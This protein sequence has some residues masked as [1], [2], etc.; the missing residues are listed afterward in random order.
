VGPVPGPPEF[1]TALRDLGYIEGQNLVVDA[2]YAGGQF[3]RLPQLARELVKLGPDIILAPG[4]AEAQAAKRVTT[5]IPIVMVT[6]VDPVG[7]GLVTSLARPGGNVTGLTSTAGSELHGKRLQMLRELAPG[8]TRI[9]LLVNPGTPATP[10]RVQATE[11]AARAL[12]VDVRVVEV[13][14]PAELNGAFSTIKQ[15]QIHA[16]LVATNRLF[17]AERVRLA[18]LAA[19]ARMPAMYDTREYVEAGG[20]AAYGPSY[21][22]LFRRAAG[23]VD[24]ILKGQKPAD[25]AVEQPTTFEFILN[26]KTANALGLGLSPA[27]LVRV[28]Q[29]IE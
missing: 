6:A 7:L 17:A 25:L 5:A 4:S 19:R 2:R 29:V 8:A 21:P 27:L 15:H 26:R 10:G 24:R 18:E 9:A 14:A 1:R 28:D 13:R 20:L 22:A 3:E 16:L 11:V 12:G 23:Y